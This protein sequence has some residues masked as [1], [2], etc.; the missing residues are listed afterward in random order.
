M[1]NINTSPC[2]D[3]LPV[4]RRLTRTSRSIRKADKCPHRSKRKQEESGEDECPPRS[5][6]IKGCNTKGCRS[7]QSRSTR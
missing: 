3:D 4:R 7:E 5:C 6:V 1:L 2:S